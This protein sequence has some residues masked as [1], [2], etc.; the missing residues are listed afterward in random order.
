MKM[1]YR[2][3]VGLWVLVATWSLSH[4]WQTHPD[5]S[6]N[7]PPPIWDWLASVYGAKNAEQAADLVSLVALVGSLILVSAMTWLI[8]FICR[9]FNICQ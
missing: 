7:L 9:R 8:L 1:I 5:T 6:L 2:V 4:W 3:L